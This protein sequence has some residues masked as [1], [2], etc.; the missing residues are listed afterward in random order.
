VKIVGFRI[1]V[2]I[3][4]FFL[5]LLSVYC[6]FDTRD[7]L[8]I[9]F[10]IVFGSFA[11]AKYEFTEDGLRLIILGVKLLTSSWY[12]MNIGFRDGTYEGGILATKIKRSVQMPLWN[13]LFFT[14]HDYRLACGYFYEC[15]GN[16]ATWDSWTRECCKNISIENAKSF[17]KG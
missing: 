13:T 6:G 7:G 4:L 15:A 8:V 10:G 17:M 5:L 11:F 16:K 1:Q 9:F 2:R 3:F 14:K 12:G